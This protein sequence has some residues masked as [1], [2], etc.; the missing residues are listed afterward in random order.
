[1][2]TERLLADCLRCPPTVAAAWFGPLQRAMTT[3]RI[4]APR[5]IAHFLA[6]IGHES[7]SLTRG[8]EN[9]RYSAKRLQE[10]G[11]DNGPGS[12]WARAAAQAD[13]L[14]NNPQAL[15]NVVY[16]NRN[17]NGPEASGDGWRYRG[18]GPIGLTGRANY[19]E[20]ATATGL[21]LVEDPDLVSSIDGGAATACA[22]WA[23]RGLN[24]Y[25]DRNDGLSIGRIINL[26][27]AKARRLPIG[28]DD[29]V[30][31]TRRAFEVLGVT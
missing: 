30:A 6:Q 22:W 29:R 25:A 7:Q 11:R 10:M 23:A 14:A 18:R 3:H 13:R 2:L 15:A 27:N 4:N 12:V 17:G 28:H 5:R 26:G 8:E 16:A 24:A 19:A 21:P 20:I 1:V 31:R 9:L